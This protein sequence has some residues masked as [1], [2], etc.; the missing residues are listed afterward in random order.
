MQIYSLGGMFN[1]GHTYLCVKSTILPNKLRVNPVVAHLGVQGTAAALVPSSRAMGGDSAA[2]DVADRIFAWG[3]LLGVLLAGVQWFALPM[4]TPWFSPLPE[5]R[6]AVK[7]PAAI[8]SFI[9]LVNGL[10]FAG[11][12]TMLGLGA[13]RDLALVTCIGVGVMVSCLASPLGRT[14][15]GV[16]LSLAAFNL[17]QGLAVTLHH[18]RISPLRRR[19]FRNG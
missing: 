5:V 6:E 10:V 8:S 16:L 12:G 18:I 2:R 19:G 11:E 1:S 9:H 17:V 4:I 3:T 15:N 13:F 14:L 7:G